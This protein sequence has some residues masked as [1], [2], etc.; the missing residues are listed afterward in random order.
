MNAPL[1][2]TQLKGH[3][4]VEGE[5][6]PQSR[7]AGQERAYGLDSHRIRLYGNYHL[8]SDNQVL[9]F[10]FL[11]TFMPFEILKKK[12]SNV[13]ISHTTHLYQKYICFSMQS[14]TWLHSKLFKVQVT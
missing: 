2:C 10:S 12:P 3:Q 13:Q 14:M 8:S 4:G 11:H 6:E 5:E 1:M 9:F 7:N